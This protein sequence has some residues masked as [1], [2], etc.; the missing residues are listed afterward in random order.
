MLTLDAPADETGYDRKMQDTIKSHDFDCRYLRFSPSGG[1]P[2]PEFVKQLGVELPAGVT[3]RE[4]VRYGWTAPS[5]RIAVPREY[6]DDWTDYPLWSRQSSVRPE[7]EVFDWAVRGEFASAVMF[8]GKGRLTGDWYLHPFDTTDRDVNEL[9]AHAL[10]L[11]EFPE[12]VEH[13]SGAVIHPY[14]DFFPYWGGYRLMESSFCANLFQ[15]IPNTPHAAAAAAQVVREIDILLRYSD[16]RLAA[17]RSSYATRANT[18]NWISMYRT[19]LAATVHARG[20]R[21]N[22]QHACRQ[23]FR[24][25]SVT[26]DELR[27][28]IRDTLLEMWHDWHWMYKTALPRGAERYLQQDIKRA[29]DFIATI[30]GTP[31]NYRDL[32]WY[33]SDRMPRRWAEL[34]DALPYEHWIAQ[35]TF[36]RRAAL[37]LTDTKRFRFR[38][39]VPTSET[40][41][42]K[43]L[44]R[45]WPMSYGFRR[46]TLLFKRLHD[47]LNRDS[48]SLVTFTDRNVIDY[49]IL[50]CLVVE[51]MVTEWWLAQNPSAAKLPSFDVMLEHLAIEFARLSGCSPINRLLHKHRDAAK[52]H[53][54]KTGA[55]L[56]LLAATSASQRQFVF[57]TLHNLRVMRNYSAHHDCLDYELSYGREGAKAMRVIVRAVALLLSLPS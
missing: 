6:F 18:F 40:E 12:A 39:P 15:P 28:Q 14:V 49:M 43:A 9:L 10:A 30:A 37:Y 32:R 8:P 23:L 57:T 4:A 16:A 41:L 24:R 46:F 20:K 55:R 5:L 38:H 36:A 26:I 52:L 27:D 3:L 35:E 25:M 13:A 50:G 56:P 33:I 2:F 22:H 54:L 42:Q 21:P 1:G 17:V 45:R 53:A 29:T 31:S 51:R 7:H 44:D 48:E 11:T 47:L 34:Y 19:M